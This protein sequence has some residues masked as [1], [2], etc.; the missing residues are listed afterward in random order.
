MTIELYLKPS[1]MFYLYMR[2]VLHVEI[3]YF[4]VR[5]GSSKL[6]LSRNMNFLIISFHVETHVC[7]ANAHVAKTRTIQHRFW[8]V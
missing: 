1:C 4:W 6:L 8:I 3:G 7:R 5:P 2:R